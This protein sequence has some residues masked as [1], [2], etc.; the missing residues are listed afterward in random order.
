MAATEI[1]DHAIQA[2]ARLPAAHPREDV[3]GVPSNWV[4]LIRAI[5]GDEDAADA[6]VSSDAGSRTITV[7]EHRLHRYPTGGPAT[8]ALGG[9]ANGDYTVSSSEYLSAS[10]QT[11]VTLEELFSA[12]SGGATIVGK[13]PVGIQNIEGALIDLLLL[14]TLALATGLQ[15]DVLGRILG[16]ARTS[17]TDATYRA[18][19]ELQAA[20]L[21]SSGQA[22]MII[23]AAASIPGATKVVYRELQPATVLLFIEGGIGTQDLRDRIRAT[24]A[25]GIRIIIAA[26][27]L[28]MFG[29]R[30]EVDSA[31]VDQ[32]AADPDA[33]GFTEAFGVTAVVTGGAGTG[34]F[35]INGDRTALFATPSSIRVYGAAAWATAEAGGVA[36]TYTIDTVT[37]IGGPATRLDVAEAVLAGAITDEQLVHDTLSTSTVG[38]L[39]ELFTT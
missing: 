10:R 28:P 1:T 13:P 20:I 5:I 11:I 31:G 17:T 16:Q 7:A 34:S 4:G 25:P 38:A 12:P 39:A 32:F 15:L 19:L 14:R 24:V 2:I 6:I 36:G 23:E 30:E 21:A 22:S 18:D 27:A 29:F 3:D 33:E 9:G 35:T 26:S 8:I 37:L